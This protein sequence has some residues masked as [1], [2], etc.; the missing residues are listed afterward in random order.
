MVEINTHGNQFAFEA[1]AMRMDVVIR[2]LG[3]LIK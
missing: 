2:I 1:D 3:L